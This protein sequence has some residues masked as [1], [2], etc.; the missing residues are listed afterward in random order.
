MTVTRTPKD[1]DF[2]GRVQSDLENRNA[3]LNLVLGVLIVIIVGVLVFNYFNRSKDLGPA[4]TSDNI[5]ETSADVTKENLPGNYTV[6]TGDTLFGIAEK[7]YD[8][9]WE[10][11]RIVE[12]NKLPNPNNIPAGQVL[13]IPKADT[14]D[15]QTTPAPS[16]ESA[17]EKAVVDATPTPSVIP[18]STPT[19]T[20][21]STWGN[22]ITENTYTVQAGDWLSTIAARAYNGDI[23]AYQ[24]IAAA[25]NITNPDLIEIGQVLKLP[26]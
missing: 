24:K 11:V 25:N 16:S 3:F 6:K 9:G 18:S 22:A 15:L 21:P 23:L 12:A 5:T 7:Y 1:Q 10:Y 2:L 8:S 19:T 26:R 13:L 17:T 14:P 20:T 4:S